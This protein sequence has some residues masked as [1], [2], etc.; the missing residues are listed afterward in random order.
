MIPLGLMLSEI[1]SNSYKHAFIQENGEISI[2]LED[3]ILIIK[4][5]GVG[6]HHLTDKM[7]NEN[8]GFNLINLL[9]DQLGIQFEMISSTQGTVYQLNLKGLLLIE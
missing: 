1:L 7:K 3:Y 8:F 9:G 6:I 2:H 4:D 5:N